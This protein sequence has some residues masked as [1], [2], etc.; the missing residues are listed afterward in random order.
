M[1]A[2]KDD[3][4]ECCFC[5]RA[6]IN[7]NQAC[8]QAQ[9][10][11]NRKPKVKQSNRKSELSK[12]NRNLIIA[13]ATA[14]L[15][16]QPDS[17]FAAPLP[18][19]LPDPDPV[20]IPF[21][22]SAAS[23]ASSA[24]NSS[25]SSSNSS[26]SC[27]ASIVPSYN[28]HFHVAAVFIV[29]ATSGLGIFGTLQ[30][31]VYE[32]KSSVSNNFKAFVATALLLFK[33]FGIGVIAATAW[34]HLLPDAFSD[35]SSP[36]LPESWQ[37]YGTN[38]VGLF[39][40]AAAFTVQLIEISAVGIKKKYSKKLVAEEHT[41]QEDDETSTNL[42]S[43]VESHSIAAV[44]PT[45]FP[46]HHATVGTNTEITF[47]D[48]FLANSIFSHP[49]HDA[50]HEHDE[51]G[52]SHMHQIESA[53]RAKISNPNIITIFDAIPS[54]HSGK[55]TTATTTPAPA[56]DAKNQTIHNHAEN[57]GHSHDANRELTTIILELGILFHSLIIGITLGVSADNAFVSL[58]VAVCFHQ[59]FE[60]M[61]LGVL[62][63]K[64]AGLS[65]GVKRGLCLMYPLTTPLG[66]VI[67]IAIRNS[68]NEN[69]PTQILVDGVLN[70]LS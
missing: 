51:S 15:F 33:M 12:L 46:T 16:V 7:K 65:D 9:L 29:M 42:P 11:R 22:A 14:I 55:D 68:Y 31:A 30:L 66:I 69:S 59:M 54:P 60:G 18:F 23:Q 38:Y 56:T 20:P 24:F 62:I 35:F 58:L 70:S 10:M 36:C 34:I 39:G 13:F 37:S 47:G 1:K 52:H 8:Q 64:L 19:P 6:C 49:H 57:N 48:S 4:C 32:R 5:C 17:V 45:V 27:I 44:A 3:C 53:I 63:G 67:G 28:F 40:L 61:S 41:D 50:K 21:P 2:H 25:S 26:N 43:R